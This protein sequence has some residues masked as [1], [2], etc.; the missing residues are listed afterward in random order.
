MTV[1]VTEKRLFEV[2]LAAM[3][4]QIAAAYRRLEL[5]L[6]NSPITVFEQDAE[7][8]YAVIHNPPPG[9]TAD[10]FVGRTDD[11]V[12][13]EADQ[14][15]IVPAKRRVLERR[16]RE[17]PRGRGRASAAARRYYDLTLEPKL[18]ADG[19]GGGRD[20]H[21]PRP[22]RAP[23][24][25]QQMRLVMRELTHRSKNLLAVIQ[26]MARKTASLSDDI[27]SFVA[28]FSARLRAMAAAQDLLVAHAWSGADLEELVRA[29]LAQSIDPASAAVRLDGPPLRLAP[30]TA[31]NL[32]LAFHE[33]TTNAAKYGALSTERGR[34]E[35]SWRQ[36]DGDVRIRWREVDGPP[37]A[38]PE[39]QGFGL[40]LLERLVGATLGGNVAMHFRPEGLECEIVFPAD[41]LVLG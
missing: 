32:G 6:E 37:V 16:A 4:A 17:T 7:L 2:R 11:E 40:V 34:V 39:R 10:D 23:A 15:R 25:E 20:R 38:A 33:L 26:A 31:Q 27:D 18:D 3:A 36:E 29:S 13:S 14:R 19:R 21:R 9:T 8:R 5:A 24:S 28:G 1:D 22:D 30:D 41:R 35:I 12:F